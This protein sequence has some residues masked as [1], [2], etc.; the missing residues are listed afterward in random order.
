VLSATDHGTP[1]LETYTLGLQGQL[2]ALST[3]SNHEIV[4]GAHHASLVSD[5]HDAQRTIP[6][7]GDIVEL[8]RQH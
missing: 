3:N 8:V 1:E 6:A 7:I 2:A 5:Q 4:A